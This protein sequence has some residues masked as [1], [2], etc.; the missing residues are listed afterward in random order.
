M[1]NICL[2]SNCAPI[3]RKGVFD[4]LD[5]NYNVTWAFGHIDSIRDLDTS[6]FKGNVVSLS[7][8][9]LPFGLYWQK[10]SIALSCKSKFDYYILIGD[11]KCLTVWL[12][13]LLAKIRGKKILF[14]S[15]GSLREVKG[16]RKIILNMFWKLADCG[17]IYNNRSRRIMADARVG[18]GN[19]VTVYNSLNYPEQLKLR[20]LLR[21]SDIYHSHF[22]NHHPVIA[23]IGRLIPSKKLDI[24]LKVA[25][26]INQ[27]MGALKVNIVIIGDGEDRLRL[28]QQTMRLG[29]VDNVWFYGPCYDEERNAELLYNADICISPGEVGLT[30][31]HALMFGL[32]VATHDN[33]DRQ[34]PEFEAI[35]DG[36]TGFFFKENDITDLCEKL[37]KWLSE[38]ADSRDEIRENCFEIIDTIWNPNH[39]ISIIR[40]TLDCL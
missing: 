9:I 10:G 21:P 40:N 35:I 24:I 37:K 30:A 34:G 14:W 20:S 17:L 7:N 33:F 4:L 38:K 27:S 1:N 2:I 19:Y 16:K 29:I 6:G 22:R 15:H 3:Y 11:A 36:K 39:Q 8:K 31:I 12:C 5:E 32:P 23:F 25:S 18:N 13:A 26:L 28:Q